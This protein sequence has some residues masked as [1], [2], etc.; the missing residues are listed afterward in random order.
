MF[1]GGAAIVAVYEDDLVAFDALTGKRVGATKTPAEIQGA[2]VVVGQ[3][4]YVALKNRTLLCLQ[5]ALTAPPPSPSPAPGESPLP[6][7]SSPVEPSV[8]PVP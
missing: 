1:L 7:R 3:R 6:S 4:L 8:P 2:P 5:L